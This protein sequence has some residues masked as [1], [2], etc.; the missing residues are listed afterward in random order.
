MPNLSWLGLSEQKVKETEKNAALS[1]QLGSIIAAAEEELVKT[2]KSKDD[3]T[4][5]QVSHSPF[6]AVQ[7][8]FP[9]III[10]TSFFI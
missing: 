9:L 6:R 3:L 7:R 10:K 5:Q 4:K 8:F 1:K 2:G